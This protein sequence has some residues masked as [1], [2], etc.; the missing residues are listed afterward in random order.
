MLQEVLTLAREAGRKILVIY[1]AGT[2]E[3]QDKQ[4]GSPLTAADLASHHAIVEG[5]RKLTPEWPILSEESAAESYEVRRHWKKYWLVDPL[6]GTKEFI[7]RNGEFTVNIALIEDGKPVMGVVHAPVLGL[8]YFAEQGG[9][10]FKQVGDAAPVPIRVALH[11]SNEKIKMVGSRSH[12]DPR[13]DDLTAHLGGGEFISMGSSLKFCL[14][15]EGTAHL[16]PRLGP[17]MEWD[18]AA[19]NSVVLEA[20]G[21]VCE[22]GG[23]A[24]RYNKADLH[25][26]PFVVLAAADTKLRTKLGEWKW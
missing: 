10:A 6:D 25:N 17:T 3:Q 5:L 12:S 24:L 15:A 14:V 23:E 8:S 13:Q 16:Y 11:T 26:P 1:D 18:T 20:G 21:I 2:A 7:K 22:G 19:A 9:G 4:D